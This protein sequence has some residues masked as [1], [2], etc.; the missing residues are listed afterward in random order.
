MAFTIP[1]PFAWDESFQVFYD[2]LDEE[3]KGLFQGVFKV[4]AN[5]ADN[6][7]F[8]ELV[9]LVVKH[10]KTEEAKFDAKSYAEAAAHKQAHADFVAKV[11]GLSAPIS[12]ET[13][14]Y[15]KEWLVNHIKGTDFKYKGQL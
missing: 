13:V 3:H 12:A 8:Q 10:F 4:A 11:G 2:E 15:A 9:A 5:P 6:A 1:E 14:S 7:T